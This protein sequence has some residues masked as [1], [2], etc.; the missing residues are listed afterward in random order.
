MVRGMTITI[1]TLRRF[2]AVLD[3]REHL[4][5]PWSRDGYVYACNGHIL[6]RVP[7]EKLPYVEPNAKCPDAGSMFKRW[8]DGSTREFLPL[9][10]FERSIKCPIC[11]GAGRLRAIKCEDCDGTGEF[12]RGRHTYQCLEC[13]D[14][15]AG[16]GFI[17]LEPDEPEQP[18]ELMCACHV[19]NGIGLHQAAS[20]DEPLIAVGNA[21]YA[22]SYLTLIAGLPGATFSA[23]APAA[24][25]FS[26]RDI[27]PGAFSFDG[28]DGLL[29][30]RTK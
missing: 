3:I 15:D 5:Q 16:E 9:P 10:N 24:E 12:K 1:E 6:V 20:L 30:P 11:I 21:L 19:C 18:G 13:E 4:R 27:N 23:G 29:M 7:E 28:G 22:T 26:G 25:G 8:I 14:S 17:A 2:C